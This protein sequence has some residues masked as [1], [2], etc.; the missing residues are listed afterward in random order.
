MVTVLAALMART[1]PARP[2]FKFRYLIV[3]ALIGIGLYAGTIFSLLVVS[4]LTRNDLP[5]CRMHLAIPRQLQTGP[6]TESTRQDLCQ[7]LDVGLN[8]KH[9]QPDQSAFAFDFWPNIRALIER[10]ELQYA[11]DWEAR[12]E[13]YRTACIQEPSLVMN[14]EYDFQGDRTFV[15]AAR[16][17]PRSD[18]LY[19]SFFQGPRDRDRLWVTWP[20]APP[21]GD[22]HSGMTIFLAGEHCGMD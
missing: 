14:C 17:Y 20:H 5:G 6:I 12:F 16:F 4:A 13:P 11:A 21:E 19:Q 7:R 8:E 22:P 10:D 3:L 2:I 9:C 15:V 18:L 1:P